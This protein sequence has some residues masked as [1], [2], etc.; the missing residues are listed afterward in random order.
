MR[1][2]ACTLAGA[3]TVLCGTS[4]TAPAAAPALFAPTS[5]WNAPLAANAALAANSVTLASRLSTEVQAEISRNIGPWI[6]TTSY[7]TPLYTVPAGQPTSQ[8]VLDNNNPTLA[9]AFAQVPLPANAQPAAGSDEELTVYQ[10]A[11]DILW[12][13]WKLHKLGT[14]WHA[15]WGGRMRNVSTDPGYYRTITSGSTILEQSWWGATASSLPVTGGLMTLSDFASG[16]INHALQLMIPYAAKGVF[17]CP[18]QRTDGQDATADA[19]PEG[20]RFRIDP[21]VDL[22]KLAMPPATRMMALAAQR[23]GMIVNDQTGWATGFRAEDPTPLTG[24]GLPN[25]YGTYFT[26]GNGHYMSPSL[27]LRSFP[28]SRLQVLA[29]PVSCT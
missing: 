28:W 26:D 14:V 16:Q 27:L 25:P 18:A 4:A 8:V 24:Q 1:A 2:L 23:Y 11:T 6:N 22:S 3:L 7:S 29:P 5:T 20:A 21:T 10:P 15:S 9:A 12:E 17:W 19:I 13:F